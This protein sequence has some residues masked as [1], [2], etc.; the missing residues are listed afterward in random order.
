MPLELIVGASLT[1]VTAIVRVAVALALA[2]SV[3]VK[4]TV[5][6]EVDGLSDVL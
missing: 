5:R 3:R 1:A 6:L 2:A 4:V